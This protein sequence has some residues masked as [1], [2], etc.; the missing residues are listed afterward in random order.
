MVYLTLALQPIES[1]RDEIMVT[2]D[3]TTTNQIESR[4]DE[5]M[6][7]PNIKAT[8]QIESRRDEIMV[9]WNKDVIQNKYDRYSA[10]SSSYFSNPHFASGGRRLF[11]LPAIVAA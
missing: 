3:A 9:S 1:R 10:S 8:S 4:R 6:V 7:T 5:I 2:P 11:P